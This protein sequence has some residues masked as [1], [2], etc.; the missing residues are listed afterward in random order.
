[1]TRI[2]LEPQIRPDGTV[3]LRAHAETVRER[4]RRIVEALKPRGSGR[5]PSRRS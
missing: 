1:M 2:V 4:V 5:S 3:V